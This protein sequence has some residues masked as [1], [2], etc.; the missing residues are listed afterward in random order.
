VRDGRSSWRVV[1][2]SAGDDLV[3]Q[4]GRGLHDRGDVLTTDT[5][6][7]KRGLQVTCD[8]AELGLGDAE[9]VVGC[10]HVLALVGLRAAE[11][12]DQERG[13]VSALLIHI[14][15]GEHRREQLVVQNTTVELVDNGLH[16]GL[17]ANAFEQV[18]GLHHL[19]LS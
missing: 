16:G 13:L 14:G 1:A 18:L 2:D 8:G 3:A 19:F 7:L 4:A 12:G 5:G 10:P 6:P 11:R 9:A 15:L 17:A